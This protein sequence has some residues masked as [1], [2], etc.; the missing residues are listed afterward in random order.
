MRRALLVLILAPACSSPARVDPAAK[1]TPPVSSADATDPCPVLTAASRSAHGGGLA[2]SLAGDDVAS[3]LPTMAAALPPTLGG[4]TRGDV[5]SMDRGQAGHWSPSASARYARGDEA[6]QVQLTDLVHVCTGAAG[7]G[8]TLARRAASAG[9]AA[10]SIAGLPA[11]ETPAPPGLRIWIHDRC[12]LALA[13]A[14]PDELAAL[15]TAVGAAALG[16]ACP[17]AR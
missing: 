7:M 17:R 6:I 8:E 3:I 9:A 5:T 15:A 2:P 12:E 14:M 4:W 11:A 16:A 13:G 10:R 1:A